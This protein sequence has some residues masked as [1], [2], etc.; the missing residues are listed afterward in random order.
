VNA[1]SHV[2]QKFLEFV[3][4]F[5]NV[6]FREKWYPWAVS[7]FLPIR[8]GRDVIFKMKIGPLKVKTLGGF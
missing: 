1:N 8:A 3:V 7:E 4:R 6:R 5:R 2:K